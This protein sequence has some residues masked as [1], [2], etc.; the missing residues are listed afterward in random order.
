MAD[1]RSLS[2][3]QMATVRPGTFRP[4]KQAAKTPDVQTITY[5]PDERV[6]LHSFGS[7]AQGKPPVSGGNYRSGGH[8]CRLPRRALKAGSPG[9]KL[10]GQSGCVPH[11][12]GSG[13]RALPLSGGHDGHYGLPEAVS[14]RG[15][16]AARCS[17]WPVCPA[18]GR[19]SPSIRIRRHRFSSMP[20]M[21][22]SEIGKPL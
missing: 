16:S 14:C 21:A 15:E 13:V 1:I 11:G 18:P 4:E 19:S 22:S 2:E 10:G 5:T 3:I 9:K 20:T 8:G 6:K 12:C 7:F 17:T